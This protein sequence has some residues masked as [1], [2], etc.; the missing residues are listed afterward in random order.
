MAVSEKFEKLILTAQLDYNAQL[1]NGAKKEL[2][3]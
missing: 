2:S 1:C 3:K